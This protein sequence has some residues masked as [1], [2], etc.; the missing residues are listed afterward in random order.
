MH[1]KDKPPRHKQ[2]NI[3]Y[4]FQCK[5]DTCGE[6]T[7]IGETKKPLHRRMYQ[8]RRPS[9]S[10]INDSFIYAHLKAS[11]HSFEDKDIVILDKEHKWCERG[12]KEAI[13]V[14]R[15][16]PSLNR[17]G[18]SDII[19]RKLTTQLSGKYLKDSRHVTIQLRHGSLNRKKISRLEDASRMRC[20]T[21]A[22]IKKC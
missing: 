22:I 12:I 6:E 17:G 2:S 19:C 7:Y 3:V 21:V 10:G 4:D 13:Y 1:P 15:E 14:I 11:Q 8:H 16:N 20:D 9:S 18:A 5:E